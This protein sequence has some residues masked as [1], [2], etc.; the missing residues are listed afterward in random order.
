MVLVDL[1]LNGKEESM[2]VCW[3]ESFS[4]STFST[5]SELS[6]S[7]G[8]DELKKK[9]ENLKGRLMTISLYHLSTKQQKEDK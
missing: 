8:M 4:L 7:Q 6:G 1:G 2:C 3:S 9:K 5:H